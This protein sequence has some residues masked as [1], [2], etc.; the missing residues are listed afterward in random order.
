[1]RWIAQLLNCYGLCE[2]SITAVLR[3][4]V[5]LPPEFKGGVQPLLECRRPY[6]WRGGGFIVGF[7]GFDETAARDLLREDE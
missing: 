7:G 3:R 1:M 2:N 6:S 4:I 5:G